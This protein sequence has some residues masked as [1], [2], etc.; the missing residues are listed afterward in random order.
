MRKNLN[1][2]DAEVLNEKV[3][4]ATGFVK[5]K[6]LFFKIKYFGISFAIFF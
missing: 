3:L 4:I 5:E 2:N 6:H 1:E